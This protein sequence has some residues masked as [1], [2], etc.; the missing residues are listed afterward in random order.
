MYRTANQGRR[1]LRRY[2]AAALALPLL[3]S[4]SCT[5]PDIVMTEKSPLYEDLQRRPYDNVVIPQESPL[6]P[7]L[8]SIGACALQTGDIDHSEGKETSILL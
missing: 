6:F 8:K 4:I 5:D 3:A 7:L 2:G 1:M